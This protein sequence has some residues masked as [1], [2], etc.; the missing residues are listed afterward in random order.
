MKKN[1]GCVSGFQRAM[2]KGCDWIRVAKDKENST[3][4]LG[5]IKARGFPECCMRVG[6]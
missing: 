2:I 3:D 6:F 1:F 4:P 5:S